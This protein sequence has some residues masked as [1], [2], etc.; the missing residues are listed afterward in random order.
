M[1][2]EHHER[3]RWNQNTRMGDNPMSANIRRLAYRVLFTGSLQ[4][5]VLNLEQQ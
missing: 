5:E 1:A 2:R 4:W 3:F